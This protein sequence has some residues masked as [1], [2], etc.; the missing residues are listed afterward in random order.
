MRET[1][2][3]LA[4]YEHELVLPEALEA[5]PSLPSRDGVFAELD[6][7]ELAAELL[8]VGN[9][10]ELELFLGRLIRRAGRAIGK[11]ARSRLGRAIGGVLKGIAKKALPIAAGALGSFVGGPVGASIGKGLATMAGKAMG[12][13][14]EGL[15][16]EDREFEAARH[17]VR[18]AGE[19][20]NNAVTKPSAA[21]PFATAEAAA[22]AAARQYAPGLLRARPSAG[23][24]ARSGQGRWHRR[25]QRII[26]FNV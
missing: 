10:Q 4:E 13:E 12:L 25:G 5:E 19:I 9:E 8:E 24:A 17:F 2:H 18:F 22:V 21:N 11:F 1:G 23:V 7:L 16:Q 26:V 14:L 6:E 15:S 20:V 3:P